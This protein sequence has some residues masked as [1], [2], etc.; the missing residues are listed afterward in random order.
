MR[1]NPLASVTLKTKTCLFILMPQVGE[2]FILIKTIRI[3]RKNT[4]RGL[5]DPLSILD[6]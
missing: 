3:V 4:Y 5:F 2:R 1:S 6:W